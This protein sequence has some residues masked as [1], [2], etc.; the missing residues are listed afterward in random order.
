MSWTYPKMIII[1]IFI[2]QDGQGTINTYDVE[3]KEVPMNFQVVV[4]NVLFEKRARR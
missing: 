2:L 3:N 4:S 1:L